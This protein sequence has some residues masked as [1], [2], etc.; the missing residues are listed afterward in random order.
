VGSLKKKTCGFFWGPAPQGQKKQTRDF[1]AGGAGRAFSRRLG[2]P[3][4]AGGLRFFEEGAPFFFFFNGPKPGF[5]GPQGRWTLALKFWG[6]TKLLFS[7]SGRFWILARAAGSGG[8]ACVQKKG[9]TGPG[10]VVVAPRYPGWGNP[11]AF[12]PILR[13]RPIYPFPCR[14]VILVS[15]PPERGFCFFLG[16]FFFFFGRFHPPA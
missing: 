14:W 12:G 10:R 9:P 1:E 16:P 2:P 6:K 7:G 13:A 15:I 8:R 4:A 3:R 11:G 5:G